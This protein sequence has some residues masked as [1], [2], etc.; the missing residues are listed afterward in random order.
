MQWFRSLEIRLIT[1]VVILATIVSAQATDS[2]PERIDWE[3][4]VLWESRYADNGRNELPEGSVFS[5]EGVASFRAFEFAAWMG[6]ADRVDYR[7][8][9]LTAAYLWEFGSVE[10]VAGYTRLEMLSEST[11]DDELFAEAGMPVGGGFAVGLATVYSFEAEGAFVDLELSRPFDLLEER[12]R[13]MPY[14]RQGLDFGYR[15][16]AH[17]GP[18]HLQVGLEWSYA[19]DERFSL[20]GYLAHSFAQEDVEREGLGDIGWGGLGFR[21]AW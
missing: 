5:V 15:T 1:P 7:E 16:E 19:L 6:E 10:M 18:N 14:V 9:N 12:L 13:L 3:T 2:R 4:T 8:L 21:A 20:L 17:D 11:S